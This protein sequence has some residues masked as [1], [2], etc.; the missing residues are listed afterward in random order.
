MT[1]RVP[2]KDSVLE[3]KTVI[4]IVVDVEADEYCGDEIDTLPAQLQEA[5]ST[6]PTP[7]PTPSSSQMD[8]F[9]DTS[10]ARGPRAAW[11]F[12]CSIVRSENAVARSVRVVVRHRPPT[13]GRKKS[14]TALHA[15]AEGVVTR[16]VATFVVVPVALLKGVAAAGRVDQMV[17]DFQQAIAAEDLHES[18]DARD[19][20]IHF[21]LATFDDKNRRESGGPRSV[22]EATLGAQ[23][24]YASSTVAGITFVATF[25]DVVAAVRHAAEFALRK[26]GA[27]ADL[28]VAA[29]TEPVSR[30]PKVDVD[31][32]KGY[33]RMLCEVFG[34]TEPRAWCIA[35]V[36][37]TMQSLI[38]ELR[39]QP[40]LPSG[41][42]AVND[43]MLSTR[44]FALANTVEPDAN[45]RGADRASKRFGLQRTA[46][47]IRAL[48]TPFDAS[49]LDGT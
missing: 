26:T 6:P 33:Q 25:K 20:R 2:F 5:K 3:A 16:C 8:S 28:E 10:A 30:G 42:V 17:A 32:A 9:Q 31:W 46:N 39:V 44:F 24:I 36:F 48:R 4:E 7:V 27:A 41:P 18:G 38:T 45:A 47:L 1:A 35:T 40:G 43:G 12:H 34:V 49:L 23:L 13:R 22:T 29:M 15:A 11:D 19:P 37:P 14:A 21:L